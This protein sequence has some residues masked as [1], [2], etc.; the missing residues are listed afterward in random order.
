MFMKYD[1]NYCQLVGEQ[2]RKLGKIVRIAYGVLSA[3]AVL[4]DTYSVLSELSMSVSSD[5]FS[6]FCLRSNEDLGSKFKAEST[7]G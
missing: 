5:K 2:A 1:P 6:K 4:A 7:A 3:A